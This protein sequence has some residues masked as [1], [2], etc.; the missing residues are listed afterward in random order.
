M[1]CNIDSYITDL[2]RNYKR[3]A[4]AGNTFLAAC[5][6]QAAERKLEQKMDIDAFFDSR[7]ETITDTRTLRNGRTVTKTATRE[8]R[9]NEKIYDG[10]LCFD[11]EEVEEEWEETFGESRCPEDF[12]E[13]WYDYC[14]EYNN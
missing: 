7:P 14:S 5:Y 10:L 2:N 13:Q 6:K 1:N 8:F 4:Q 11:T 12:R 3:H 9:K